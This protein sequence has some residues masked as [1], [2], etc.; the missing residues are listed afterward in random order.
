MGSD[1]VLA[2]AIALVMLLFVTV[3]GFLDALWFMQAMGWG[4]MSEAFGRNR[5]FL[6]LIPVVRY[7]PLG[8]VISRGKRASRVIWTVLLM[9]S[10]IGLAIALLLAIP[11]SGAIHNYTVEL[12]YDMRYI[13][14]GMQTAM[15]CIVGLVVLVWRTVLSAGHLTVYLRCFKKWLAV[16]LGV[17]GVVLPVA[18]FALLAVAHRRK[19]SHDPAETEEAE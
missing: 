11:V 17:C 16:V 18:P 8:L 7:V 1:W 14:E 3:A 5:T 13:G 4:K 9:L 19:D 6:C 2:A 12:D 15:W 10:G